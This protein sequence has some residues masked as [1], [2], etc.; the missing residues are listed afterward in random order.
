M[1]KCVQCDFL[2]YLVS[3]MINLFICTIV[4]MEHYMNSASLLWMVC[5]SVCLSVRLLQTRSTL[6]QM[7][8]GSRDY[9]EQNIIQHIR[10]TRSS[11][12]VRRLMSLNISRKVIRN[13][14]LE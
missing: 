4:H 13:K 11:E 3:S 9:H 12:A 14:T 8:I 6:R 1:K 7:N 5:Q 2:S 10:V